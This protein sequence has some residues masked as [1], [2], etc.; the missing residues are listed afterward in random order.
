MYGWF[1]VNGNGDV[2][3]RNSANIRVY[4]EIEIDAENGVSQ[5]HFNA[6]DNN[7]PYDAD[8]LI[9]Q[10]TDIKDMVNFIGDYIK[11]YNSANI[12]SK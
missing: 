1:K 6:Y 9:H 12:T 3:Y 4:Y 11:R 7:M 10:T 8:E 2:L 5:I